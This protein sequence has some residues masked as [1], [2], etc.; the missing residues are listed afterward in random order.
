[1]VEA[2]EDFK[3][4]LG[5]DVSIKLLTIARSFCRDYIVNKQLECLGECE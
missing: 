5:E 3:R 2:Q 1:M 4:D